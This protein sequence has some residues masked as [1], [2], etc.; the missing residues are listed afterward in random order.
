MRVGVNPTGD[1]GPAAAH[2]P[3]RPSDSGRRRRQAGGHENEVDNFRT[4]QAPET[5]RRTREKYRPANINPEGWTPFLLNYVGDVDKELADRLTQS[6]SN[7]EGWRGTALVP[8]VDQ[9]VPLIADD[10][11]LTYLPLAILEAE[12]ARLEKLV[13]IDR[14]TA[15]KFAAVSKRLIEE[16]AALER[17]SQRLADCEGAK[18][19]QPKTTGSGARSRLHSRVRSSRGRA[20]RTRRTL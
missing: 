3:L 8:S 6:K 11:E 17:T 16:N 7:A 19:W 10:A 2:S 14:E 4:H 12:T 13:S 15:S 1:S 9:S 20:K 5:L 18:G